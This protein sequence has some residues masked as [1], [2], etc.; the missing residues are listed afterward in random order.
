MGTYDEETRIFQDNHVLS[1][2]FIIVGKSKKM[3]S[4]PGKVLKKLLEVHQK[5]QKKKTG[6]Q[7]TFMI[8]QH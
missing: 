6:L 8:P 2:N 5:D 7:T 1:Q 4:N 3:I